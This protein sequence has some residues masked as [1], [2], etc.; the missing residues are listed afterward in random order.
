MGSAQITYQVLINGKA[1]NDLTKAL[2]EATVSESVDSMSCFNARF[3]IDLCDTSSEIIDKKELAPGKGTLL[4]LLAFIDGNGQVLI[5]GPITGRSLEARQGGPGSALELSGSD[6]RIEMDRNWFTPKAHTGNAHT[7]AQGILKDYFGSNVTIA[8]EGE[9]YSPEAADATGLIQTTSD[10]RLVERIA[11]SANG[12]LWIDWAYIAGRVLETAHIESVP[13]LNNALNPTFAPP[14]LSSLAP[15]TQP[16]T[17]TMNAGNGL[18]TILALRNVRA[19]EVPNRGGADRVDIHDGSVQS[20]SFE[21][22]TQPP[23]G[24]S[25]PAPQGLIATVV[26]AGDISYVQTR[27]SSALNDAAFSA[28]QVRCETTAHALCGILR[29]RQLVNVNGTGTEEDGQY[30][31]WSV[32][33]SFDPADHRMSLTLARNAVKA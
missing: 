27:L 10:L 2:A 25:P 20:T 9:K 6:R 24:A 26:T 16:P 33:H 8:V 23:L 7:I 18:D 17:L 21:A 11:R 14:F 30:L 32:D 1:D 31:V 28:A 15:S 5:H 3:A 22:P 4:T 19:T 12:K 13:P 29:P